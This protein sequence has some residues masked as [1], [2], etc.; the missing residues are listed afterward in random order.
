MRPGGTTAIGRLGATPVAGTDERSAREVIAAPRPASVRIAGLAA[1]LNLT[2]LNCQLWSMPSIDAATLKV[3]QPYLALGARLGTLVQQLGPK[4]IEKLKVAYWGKVVDLDANSLTRSIIKGYLT[5]I[6]GDEV[7]FV[8][9]PVVLERLG[10]Q[11]EVTKST[12]ESDYTELVQVEALTGDRVC[13][14]AAGTLIG[15]ASAPRVVSMIVSRRALTGRATRSSVR[16]R[17]RRRSTRRRPV[18]VAGHRTRA[19]GRRPGA[20]HRSSHPWP[21]PRTS[22]TL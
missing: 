11:L 22:R 1:V 16:H 8:N 6:S 17:S 5:Q 14:S 12:L 15:K 21:R 13:S 4:S 18:R 20:R 2:A 3:I 9:A 10:V 7:N 19:R